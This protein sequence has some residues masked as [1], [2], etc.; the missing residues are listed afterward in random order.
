MV[1]AHSP[2]DPLFDVSWNKSGDDKYKIA[3]NLESLLS[4]LK[5]SNN[6]VRRG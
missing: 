4:N 5:I 1:A 6:P 3:I 2:I